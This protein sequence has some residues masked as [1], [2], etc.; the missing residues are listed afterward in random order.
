MKH[1]V[2]GILVKSIEVVCRRVILVTGPCPSTPDPQT[3]TVLFL[4]AV[5]TRLLFVCQAKRKKPAAPE[6]PAKKQ[7]SGESSKPSA[8]SKSSA[9][10]GGGGDDNMFQVRRRGMQLVCVTPVILTFD[11]LQ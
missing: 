6:K 8:S 11:L 1:F 3:D 7:K 2:T 4:S 9:D 5:T 10:G